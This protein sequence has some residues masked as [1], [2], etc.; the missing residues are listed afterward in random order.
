M[1]SSQ[2]AASIHNFRK[3]TRTMLCL[4]QLFAS[5]Y[6]LAKMAGNFSE[7]VLRFSLAIHCYTWDFYTTEC[8]FDLLEAN[9]QMSEGS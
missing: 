8:G 2:Y 7:V 9:I 3:F 5:A 4:L 6:C 1:D